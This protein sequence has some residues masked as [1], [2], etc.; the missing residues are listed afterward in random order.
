L[1]RI[2]RGRRSFEV[3][4]SPSKATLAEAIDTVRQTGERSIEAEL[5]SVKGELLQQK[6]NGAQQKESE[7][8]FQKALQIA[9]Q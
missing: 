7:S 1:L 5:Y 9:R 2:L 3:V 8:C 6:A 4:A